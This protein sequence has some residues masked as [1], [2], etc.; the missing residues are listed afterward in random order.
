MSW[1]LKPFGELYDIPS[2]NGLSLP[3]NKRGHGC[4]MINMGELFAYPRIM[5]P[6]M[7]R[8]QP[9]ET[10]IS[11]YAVKIDDLLFARRSLVLEGAGKCAI[12][13]D[14]DDPTVFESSIIRV[15]LNQE[16][17]DPKFYFY[18][19]S[20]Q[21]GTGFMQ[22]IVSQVAV[23]GIRGSDL[24]KL[25]V[26]YPPLLVQKKIA[27]IL[28]AYD[29]LIENNNKRIDLLEKAAEEIYREWFI[30]MRFP[31][32]KQVIF[33]KGLPN[34]W[35]IQPFSEVVG[36]KPTETVEK[37]TPMPFAGMGDLSTN[38]MMF[39]FS[40]T[41]TDGSGTKF[42]NHDTLFPRI[43][44]SVENGKRGYVMNLEDGQVGLGSTEFIVFREKVVTSEYIYFT[45]CLPEFRKHAELSM[46]GASGRQRVQEDCFDY[47]LVKVPDGKTLKKFTDIV[48]PFFYEI[49]AIY[50]SN[51]KL[52]Q[53]RDLLLPRLISGKLSVEA[54]DIRFPPSMIAQ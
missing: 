20:S 33:V 24:E 22:Q 28:S 11:K 19:F 54:L 15:R 25:K 44:P 9:S 52:K 37:K 47:F 31:G 48:R 50:T 49:K 16:I 35:K 12:V 17:S 39:S 42:R 29:D 45:T 4:K 27:A 3:A 1:D 30:R 32:W 46:T 23:A 34:G 18:F 8:V 21:A 51:F 13:A 26:I 38:S 40:E 43:T 2:R 14:T 41:R 36:L 7:A 53:S 10:E 5:N 6:E